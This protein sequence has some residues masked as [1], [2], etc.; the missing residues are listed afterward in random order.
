MCRI[1]TGCRNAQD[2]FELTEIL[3]LWDYKFLL[4]VTGC[5]KTQMSNSVLLYLS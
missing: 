4:H 3:C 5:L 1:C 2:L